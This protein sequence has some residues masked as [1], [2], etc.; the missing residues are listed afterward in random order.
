MSWRRVNCCIL[1][2]YEFSEIQAA[3]FMDNYTKSYR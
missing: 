1:Y 3:G 2:N